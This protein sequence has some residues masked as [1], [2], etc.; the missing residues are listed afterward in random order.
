M[1]RMAGK[2]TVRK[3]S[4]NRIIDMEKARKER[5]KQKMAQTS[6]EKKA[7]S[8]L[9]KKRQRLI[10]LAVLV[11]V[12]ALGC[13]VFYRLASLHSESRN[14]Q[15]EL[16]ALEKEKISLEEELQRVNE[17]E[18]VE[19]KA[20]D[21]LQMIMPDETLYVVEKKEDKEDDKN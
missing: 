4:D 9:G 6:T 2:K 5:Q 20:R 1:G 17:P 13:G 12:I 15:A 19:Q 10:S 21:E 3:P 16:E 7:T 11:L 14:A 18:Y 8:A